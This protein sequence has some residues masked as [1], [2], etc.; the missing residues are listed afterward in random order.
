MKNREYRVLVTLALMASL[1][2]GNVAGTTGTV[3][4]ADNKDT[5]TKKTI[6]TKYSLKYYKYKILSKITFGKIKRKYREKYKNLN[7][8]KLN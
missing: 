3:Q 5:E 8:S 4:A 7:E 2:I 1:V 6:E